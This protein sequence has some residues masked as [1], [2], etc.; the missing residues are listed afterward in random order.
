MKKKI[1]I[2]ILPVIAMVLMTGCFGSSQKEKTSVDLGNNLI[3][4]TLTGDFSL[5]DGIVRNEDMESTKTKITSFRDDSI[6]VT[7]AMLNDKYGEIIDTKTVE[8]FKKSVHNM[9]N[10]VE[11]S[12]TQDEGK[13]SV[14]VKMKGFDWNKTFGKAM[15]ETLNSMMKYLVSSSTG[16]VQTAPSEE[17][18]VKNIKKFMLE[19]VVKMKD[20]ADNAI[21]NTDKTFT[22]D[23]I[24][25]G[26]S[27]K[28]SDVKK[29]VADITNNAIITLSQQ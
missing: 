26:E 8:D 15:E 18:T 16:N 20:V 5:L 13:D 28:F 21:P 6:L 23:I 12:V 3:K 27:L 17:E 22:I 2:F 7:T 29:V 25:D 24:K 14:T 4:A 11:Y 9:I 19:T 10:K 1:N